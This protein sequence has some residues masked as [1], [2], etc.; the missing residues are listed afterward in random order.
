MRAILIDSENKTLSELQI[1]VKM[2]MTALIIY[3]RSC[4]AS[5]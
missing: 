3:R 4:S 1:S 5:L 2:M